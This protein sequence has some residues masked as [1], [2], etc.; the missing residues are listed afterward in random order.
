MALAA[1]TPP[2][3]LPESKSRF[4]SPAKLHRTV[5][6]WGTCASIDKQLGQAREP[7]STRPNHEM[8]RLASAYPL[9]RL[10]VERFGRLSVGPSRLLD[11]LNP[12]ELTATVRN[13]RLNCSAAQRINVL[14]FLRH[15]HHFLHRRCAERDLLPAVLPQI[16]HAVLP[17]GL[18]Q[19]PS[20]GILHDQVS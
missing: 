5:H 8:S 2:L 11:H 7:L 17:C 10:S 12:L 4:F 14:E 9:S 13:Q 6:P 16:A 1:R 15:P 19:P 20:V 3:C 18:R